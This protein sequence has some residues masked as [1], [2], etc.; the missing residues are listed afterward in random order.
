MSFIRN[1]QRVK[2]IKTSTISRKANIKI[3]NCSM[4]SS[5]Q[6]EP[7]TAPGCLVRNPGLGFMAIVARIL[8][9][10]FILLPGFLSYALLF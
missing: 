8:I 6:W 3:V 7:F 10:G 9:V 2:A 1:I 5:F 4:I